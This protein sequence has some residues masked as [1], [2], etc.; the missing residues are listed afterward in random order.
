MS[1]HPNILWL[2]TDQQTIANRP[3]PA[4][5]L[6]LQ[7][8]L[9]AQG[10]N[11]RRAYT[12]LPICS[13]ARASMLTG[14][15]PHNHG[16]TENDGRFGGRA[17]LE[18]SDTLV[19]GLL[20]ERGYRCAWF[21]KWHLHQ[22]LD[23]RAFGFEGYAPAGYAYPYASAD[24]RAYLERNA[25]PDPIARIELSGE[26][27]TPPGKEI[28]LTRAQDWFDFEAGSAILEGPAET[29]EAFFVA[30]LAE[31]WLRDP[32]DGPF[33]MRV[34]TW[35]P[36][37]P[38]LVGAPFAGMFADLDSAASP[39]L[40]SDLKARPAHHAAYRDHWRDILDDGARDFAL[41]SRRALQSASLCEAALVRLLDVLEDSGRIDDTIIIFTADHGDAVASNGGMMN[42]GGLMVE[43]T[44]RIPMLI[45]GPG[46]PQGS[47]DSLVCNI[48]VA[49]TLLDLC[50]IAAHEMDGTSLSSLLRR[51]G[52]LP[53]DGLM[54][55]HY[56]LTTPLW[57]RAFHKGRWKLVVQDD[58]F[59]E[60][61]DL[62]CDPAEMNNLAASAVHAGT[63]RDMR[64]GLAKALA[65]YGDDS[66][67]AMTIRDT[68][69]SDPVSF[70]SRYPG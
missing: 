16:L 57:Q 30:E 59:T 15:Y 63:L 48:D 45:A 49:P 62:A 32:G 54:T 1:D 53:R 22:E 4:R 37:P 6:P 8:R 38:Y 10:M 56:G 50:G 67:P 23:A 36:H 18:P 26:S 19:T 40:V 65:R 9:A 61:Y 68:A 21:G 29:H 64:G 47:N 41:L 58:G 24:Y 3:G 43:E 12:V 5:K 55:E 66:A 44:L 27:G 17:G 34:D 33:F 28:T 39:N 35:G 7:T 14:L 20:R 46:I 70:P 31:R 51:T 42:K 2:N 69:M 60:L 13:P 11:F 52:P 25:L